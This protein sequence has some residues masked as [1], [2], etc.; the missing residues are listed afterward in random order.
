ML[1][2][3][4]F[5]EAVFKAPKEAL[6]GV[7]LSEVEL[8]WLLQSDRRAWRLDPMR[9]TRMLQSLIEE[10]PV[11]AALTLQHDGSAE[12]LDAFFSSPQLHQSVQSRG[13]LSAAFASYLETLG[14]PPMEPI[15]A[16][17]AA[18]AKCRHAISEPTLAA[19]LIRLAPCHDTLKLPTG[20]LERYATFSGL[21]RHSADANQ[22]GLETML[23]AGFELPNALAALPESEEYIL[24]EPT[25]DG[26]RLG[27]I[28]PALGELLSAAKT[29][30]TLPD[31]LA[32]ATSL[33][34]EPDEA[35]E[36]I[37]E[38]SAEGLLA[39]RP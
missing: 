16:I 12:R 35:A 18:I 1:I 7:D 33:G 36:I 19:G 9:R 17:E 22:S 3:S 15:R 23:S 8:E 28:P 2:D 34:A 10:F 20:S 21:L 26:P 25:D 29:G 39:R 4:C 14:I 37:D 13:Y 38:L 11:A 31:L 6:V 24:V 27:E 32:V 30:I 5:S